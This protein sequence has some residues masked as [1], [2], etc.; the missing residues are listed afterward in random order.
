MMK[1]STGTP[2]TRRRGERGQTLAE[3]A[4]AAPIFFLLVFGVVDMARLYQSWVTIQ[5]AA[6]EGARYGVT[7]RTDC[8]VV[9]PTREACIEHVARIQTGGLHDPENDLTVGFR[10]WGYPAYAD[11]PVD[12]SAGD[13]CDALE[14]N[15]GYDFS[16]ATPILGSIIGS[17]HIT[18]R[19]RLVNEPF[20]PCAT[21]S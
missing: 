10:S 21:E 11:P 17:V 15:V 18:A 14:V 4:L 6:R 12:D 3:F 9:T 7:G 19:E 5:H 20:G 1:R 8:D 16:P 13:Q 2:G